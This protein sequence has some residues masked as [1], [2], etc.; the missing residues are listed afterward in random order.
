MPAGMLSNKRRRAGGAVAV[1]VATLM[2]LFVIMVMGILEIA[3][4][5]FLW[6]TLSAVTRRGASAIAAAAPTA[7]HSD[8]LDRAAFGGV[9]LSTPRIDGS[10]LRVTYLNAARDIVSAPPVCPSDNVVTCMADPTGAGCVRYVQVRLCQPGAG[11]ACNPVQVT[12]LVG[13]TRLLFANAQ[14]YFP[15]FQTVTPVGALGYQPGG[16]S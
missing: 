12:P 15:T 9:P 16:C 13:I 3:R 10:Y 14:L 4:I 5:M 1:E 11:D 6:N 7:D 8:A 2:L